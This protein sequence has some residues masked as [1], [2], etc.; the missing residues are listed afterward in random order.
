MNRATSKSVL[1][2]YREGG[3]CATSGGCYVERNG[4]L[5]VDGARR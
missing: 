2:D 5:S 4:V 1:T 3:Y